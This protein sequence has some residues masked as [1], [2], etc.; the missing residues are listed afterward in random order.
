MPGSPRIQGSKEFDPLAFPG[1]AGAGKTIEQYRK[2]Q[3][4]FSQGDIANA[5]IFIRNGKVK[6][7]VVSEHGKEV[8]FGL[9]KEKQFFGE[10][11]LDGTK[12]RGAT[13]ML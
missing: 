1:R 8:V 10:G 11:C 9:F 3:K 6:L 12:L 7:T 5:V 13:G 2:N 4:I